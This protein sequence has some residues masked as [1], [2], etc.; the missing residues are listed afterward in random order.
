[1][2]LPNASDEIKETV[3]A[4][5]AA[6]REYEELILRGDFYRI[7]S[8]FD[9]NYY[10]YYFTNAERSEFLLSFEQSYGESASRVYLFIP[11]ADENAEYLDTVSGEVF[12]GK[13]LTR[14]IEVKTKE[15][16]P[17]S[18]MWHFVKK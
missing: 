12:S 15:T 3:K 8:P 1:M 7:F 4:Q 5:V 10:A 6:Y 2:H 18:V 16:D 17:Y 11:E 14:G 9:S 13:T